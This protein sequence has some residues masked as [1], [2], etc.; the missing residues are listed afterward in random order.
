VQIILDQGHIMAVSDTSITVNIITAV[1][2]GTLAVFAAMGL[3]ITG[4]AKIAGRGES[5]P[6]A[7]M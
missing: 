3:L 4:Y 1:I 2:L 6:P 5:K 7:A